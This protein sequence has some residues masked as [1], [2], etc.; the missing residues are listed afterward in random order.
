MAGQTTEPYGRL[1]RYPNVK[2]VF[3][4]IALLVFLIAVGHLFVI[5]GMNDI[6]LGLPQWLWLQNGVF[7]LMI[8][9]A[10][11]AVRLRALAMERGV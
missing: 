6:V 8:V 4:G 5:K 11:V 2:Y 1:V 7:V 3:Y 9:L 10:W